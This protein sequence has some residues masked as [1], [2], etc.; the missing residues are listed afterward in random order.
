MQTTVL[1]AARK[2]AAIAV[3]SVTLTSAFSLISVVASSEVASA[4]DAVPTCTLYWTGAVNSAWENAGNWSLTN[5]GPTASRVPTISDE[6]CFSTSPGTASVTLSSSSTIAGIQW[7]VVGRVTPHLTVNWNGALEI[8][9]DSSAVIANLSDSATITVDRYALLSVTTLTT[10]GVP[11]FSGPGGIQVS[12]GGTATLAGSSPT[13][14]NRVSFD[15]YGTTSLTAQ[16]SIF[17]SDGAVLENDG[18]FN[19]ATGTDLCDVDLTGSY[20]VNDATGVVNV[21]ATTANVTVHVPTTNSGTINV[22]AGGLT[23]FQEVL[24]TGTFNIG[25]HTLTVTGSYRGTARSVA[26][27]TLDASGSGVFN[28]GVGAHLAGETNVTV[29]PSF[30]FSGTSTT[31]NVVT[32]IAGMNTCFGGRV[33]NVSYVVVTGAR[34]FTTSNTT[35]GTKV[36]LTK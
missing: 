21:N 30:T 24:N 13:L 31:V 32:V 36:T 7:P 16:T 15:N 14:T 2:F 33:Q 23:L 4:T 8:T 17:L 12:S 9:S 1:A 26:N 5:N 34:H 29:A 25:D 3:A 27:V 18:T 11:V 22:L 6:L 19:L 10:S 20:F 35:A 28:G